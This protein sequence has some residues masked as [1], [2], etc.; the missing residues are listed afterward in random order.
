MVGTEIHFSSQKHYRKYCKSTII[1][2][3]LNNKQTKKN[4]NGEK[5]LKWQNKTRIFWKVLLFGCFQASHGGG[6]WKFLGKGSN[7][8]SWSYS[9]QPMSQPQPQGS[10]LRVT[11]TTAH[12]ST[13][14]LTHRVRPGVEPT[15]SW[16]VFRFFT[17]WATMGTPEKVLLILIFRNC[18]PKKIQTNRDGLLDSTFLLINMKSDIYNDQILVFNTIVGVQKDR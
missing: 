17:H 7:P 11:Y 10:E 5:E 16:I 18:K 13:G 6:M 8:S 15:S 4:H 12:G 9:C 1:H 3:F 2:Y 14:S